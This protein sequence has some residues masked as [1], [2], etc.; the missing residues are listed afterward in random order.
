MRGQCENHNEPNSW[1]VLCDKHVQHPTGLE[2]TNIY[3]N[4]DGSSA[5]CR[6]WAAL[7]DSSSNNQ[8]KG[9]YMK[10]AE[11]INLELNAMRREAENRRYCLQGTIYTHMY[12]SSSLSNDDFKN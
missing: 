4:K 3:C 6:P 12:C 5:Q 2:T 1:R 11:I 7:M 8:A 9:C 10:R